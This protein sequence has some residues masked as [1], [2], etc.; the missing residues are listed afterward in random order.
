MQAL[1]TAGYRAAPKGRAA[2]VVVAAHDTPAFAKRNADLVCDG[3]DDQETINAAVAKLLRN[4]DVQVLGSR[5]V[6]YGNEGGTVL[7]LAGSY[8][9][10][11]PIDL[12]G[13][14]DVTLEGE[15][16]ATVIYNESVAG[17]HA[18]QAIN[19]GAPKNRVTIRNLLVQGN[20]SSGNGIH[21]QET[22]YTRFIDVF[23]VGHGGH[24]FFL[25]ADTE[26]GGAENH[27]ITGCMA[28][29]N[30]QDGLRLEKTHE[31]LVS[32]CHLEEN[33][34]YNLS[35]DFPVNLHVTNCSIEDG[36]GP[37][38]VYINPAGH[39][40]FSN[41]TIEGE[42]YIASSGV[43]D[44][45]TVFSGCDMIGLTFTRLGSWG[46]LYISDSNLILRAINAERCVISNSTVLLGDADGAG[47]AGSLQVATALTVNGGTLRPLGG[48]QTYQFQVSGTSGAMIFTGVYIW[49]LLAVFGVSGAPSS[50]R[51]QFSG[52][53]LRAPRISVN[54]VQIV[55]ITGGQI[56]G[57]G[58]LTFDEVD[59]MLFIANNILN[60]GGGT[61]AIT[62]KETCNGKINMEANQRSTT[63][64][65]VTD[66]TGT[67]VINDL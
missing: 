38:E 12:S 32:Q 27:I 22:N 19:T 58:S 15:G 59:D 6:T 39:V 31:T 52:C 33:Y 26:T 49:E 60:K 63:G 1:A 10:S 23:S 53:H 18:I 36:Y 13:I 66:N 51:L 21:V 40:L 28:L 62:F 24:G 34:R 7:L 14:H 8:H 29:F 30:K 64:I 65:T 4:G 17:T 61:L 56:T 57:A 43:S 41:V 16:P 44:Y 54:G 50:T 46:R 37:Y 25:R 67:A 20:P 35:A 42:T 2:T 55:S 9:L 48:A 3:V 45:P 11:G 5:E 47:T